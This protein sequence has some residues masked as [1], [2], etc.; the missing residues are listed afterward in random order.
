MDVY[1]LQILKKQ[2][3]IISKDKKKTINYYHSSLS[4]F[5]Y[6]IVTANMSQFWN[7]ENTH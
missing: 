2:Q 6:K 5:I 3:A 4:H 1:Q 7:E